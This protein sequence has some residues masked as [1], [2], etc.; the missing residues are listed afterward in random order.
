MHYLTSNF[1][2]M[3]S[4]SHWDKLKNNHTVIDKNYNGLT[5]SLNKK[6]L[7]NYSF[8]HSILYI[9][10]SNFNQTIKELKNFTRIVNRYKKKYF[11]LYLFNNFYKNPIQEKIFS[12]HLL[13]IK[14]DLENL[15]IKTFDHNNSKLFSERNRIYIRFPFELKFMLPLK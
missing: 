6:N 5:I 2:L 8:F 7:D 14:F 3:N 10:G 15:I 13:K 11:F 9:D 12:D 4:N 1:N